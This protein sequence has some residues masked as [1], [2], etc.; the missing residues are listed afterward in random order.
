M[1]DLLPQNVLDDIL[2]ETGAMDISAASRVFKGH[3]K[4]FDFEQ[5]KKKTLDLAV[6]EK[7]LEKLTDSIE[8]DW[9]LNYFEDCAIQREK[10][11]VENLAEYQFRENC[12]CS[13]LTTELIKESFLVYMSIETF[14]FLLNDYLGGENAESHKENEILTEIE[15]YFLKQ[16]MEKICLHITRSFA[17]LG[18]LDL[19][20]VN[21]EFAIE[22]Q[23]KELYTKHLVVELVTEKEKDSFK[24]SLA[25]PLTFASYLEEKAAERTHVAGRQDDPLW[26]AAVT[27][28]FYS[29]DLDLNVSLGQISI[30]FDRFLNLKAGEVFSWDKT[31]P[32]VT[33]YQ[34]DKPV[35]KGT[36]GVVDGNF[37]VRVEEL[38]Y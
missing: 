36:I 25:I 15:Q 28:A 23:D 20:L 35:V 24:F 5:K 33:V 13:Q 26:Q 21:T 31:S 32:Q 12:F 37:A 34:Y 8:K 4:R 11:Q 19:K 38:M 14:Y 2:R 1:K 27:N 3:F 18:K 9:K 17:Y 30:P 10:E 7:G 6:F 22:D 16:I 29:S